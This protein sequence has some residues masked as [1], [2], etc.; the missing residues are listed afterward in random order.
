MSSTTEPRPEPEE[1][2]AGE[3]DTP[4]RQGRRGRAA[5]ARLLGRLPVRWHHPLLFVW[6]LAW[7][8]FVERHGGLSWHYVRTGTRLLFGNDFGEA[9]GVSGLHLYAQHPE[10]QIG[11]VSFVVACLF[12]YLKA[13]QGQLLAEAFMSAIGL[14]ILVLAGRSAA[15]H[16]R[17]RSV[18]HRLLQRRVFIAGLAFIPMWVEVSVRFAHLDDVLALFFA[19]LAVNAVSQGR[20]TLVGV[21]LGLAVD[22]KP[23]ALAFLP[24]LLATRAGERLRPAL[25]ACGVIAA[26]WSPFLLIDVRSLTAGRF[27]IPVQ[28]ASP[29]HWLGVYEAGTPWWDRPAQILLGLLLGVLAVRRDRWPA[30]VLLGVNA[31][32]VL[33]PSVYTYYTA[34]VLLGTLLWDTLGERRLLPVWSWIALFSLYGTIF[35]VGSAPLRGLIRIAFVVISTGYVLM[36]PKPDARPGLRRRKV[37]F[38]WQ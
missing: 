11:P 13:A 34:S 6:T 20:A 3:D 5:T 29:L 14:Y 15:N 37:S 26:A 18:D 31:R 22:S 9:G 38:P 16:F 10:L 32:I 33:D 19:A 21:Y 28:A 23:W 2:S 25:W 35:V 12:S 17:W 24:L 7:F 30:V 1:T 36:W 27:A 4:G 8:V